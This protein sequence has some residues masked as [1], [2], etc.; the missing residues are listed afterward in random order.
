[1]DLADLDPGL[2]L[3]LHALLRDA[4]V[5]HAAT[6]LGISQPALSARVARL[7]ELYGDP[8]FVPASGGRGV[9][10]TPFA[11]SLRPVLDEALAQLRRLADHGDAFDPASSRR[12]FTIAAYENPAAILAPTLAARIAAAAPAVRLAVVT[13]GPDIAARLGSGD[14][15]LLLAAGRDHEELVCRKLLDSD[16]ATAQR[17]AH[18]RG[19][20]PFDLDTFCALDHVLISTEGGG[21]AGV[22]DHAL[23]ALGRTRRV[24]MSVQSYAL[25]PLIVA[26]SDCICTMPRRILE[27]FNADLDVFAPPLALPSAALFAFWHPRSQTD[28]GHAWLR[29]QL[30]AVAKAPLES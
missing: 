3:A 1:M 19:T 8:L 24:A 29:E 21:F 10:P 28:Q 11:A 6:R 5:T 26:G 15:D 12:T 14:A 4:N 20:G 7:R 2:L 22:V 23:S 30:Y 27:R 13:T 25:A 9:V 18:P 16:Y 17:R